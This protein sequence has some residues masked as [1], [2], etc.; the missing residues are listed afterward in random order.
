[1]GGFFSLP[2]RLLPETHFGDERH[3]GQR[4]LPPPDNDAQGRPVLSEQ[5]GAECL[6]GCCGHAEN[7]PQTHAQ[8]QPRP[9][10]HHQPQ[11]PRRAHPR[12]PFRPTTVPESRIASTRSAFD[13]K[14]VLLRDKNCED[15]FSKPDAPSWQL[16]QE[17]QQQTDQQRAQPPPTAMAAQPDPKLDPAAKP[18]LPLSKTET[19]DTASSPESVYFSPPTS[20]PSPSSYLSPSS[21]AYFTAPEH[22]E[23]SSGEEDQESPPAAAIN[24]VWTSPAEQVRVRFN[25][26]HTQATHLGLVS[27]PF[28]PKTLSE[29]LAVQQLTLER[30]TQRLKAQLRDREE[31]RKRQEKGEGSSWARVPLLGPTGEVEHTWAP[32]SPTEPAPTKPKPKPTPRPTPA[33]INTSA[34]TSGNTPAADTPSNCYGTCRNSTEVPAPSPI[35]TL[36]VE[37]EN[38]TSSLLTS[39][40]TSEDPTSATTT[41]AVFSQT[42]SLHLEPPRSCNLLT[43]AVSDRQLD[44]GLAGSQPDCR[45]HPLRQ[46]SEYPT[47]DFLGPTSCSHTAE[48]RPRRLH[49]AS[50][51][52]SPDRRHHPPLH[53]RK[54]SPPHDNLPTH[55]PL[56]HALSS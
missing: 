22:P 47:F 16:P 39:F 33:G 1:M 4:I 27:S 53:Q 56:T 8:H 18:F 36:L 7:Q 30:K 35:L 43:L 55:L 34:D 50:L 41:K 6:N 14:S 12:S 13:R 42:V 2:D 48:P 37:E 45:Y 38:P 54:S 15:K 3:Q 29:Y 17:K 46:S 31:A 40:S 23:A 20:A 44:P 24:R 25:T 52:A 9:H 11:D 19:L 5:E 49:Q 21:S 28:F 10:D 26:I 32:V 51:G